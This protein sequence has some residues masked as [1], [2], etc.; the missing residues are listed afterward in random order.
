MMEPHSRYEE[1][2]LGEQTLDYNPEN[3]KEYLLF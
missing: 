3:P 2:D 1:I